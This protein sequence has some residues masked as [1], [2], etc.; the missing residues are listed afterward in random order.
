MIE[1]LL[2]FLIFLGFRL[3]WTLLVSSVLG[4]IVYAVAQACGATNR[5]AAFIAVGVVF[6]PCIFHMVL[7]WLGV[8]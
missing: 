6:A 4:L 7:F 3:I 2:L 1:I 5:N 8:G